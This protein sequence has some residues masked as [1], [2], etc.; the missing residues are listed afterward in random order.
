MLLVS[1][2][3]LHLFTGR[4]GNLLHRVREEQ[5]ADVGKEFLEA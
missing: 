3:L 4:I 2:R 1:M 5:V